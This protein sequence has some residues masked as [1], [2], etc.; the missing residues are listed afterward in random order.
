MANAASVLQF[1]GDWGF[2]V[3]FG[4]PTDR[5]KYL[6]YPDFPS[7]MTFAEKAKIAQIC[8]T[9]PSMRTESTHWLPGSSPPSSAYCPSPPM[10]TTPGRQH[11]WNTNSPP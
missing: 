9:P 7:V 8:R 1:N 10:A 6:V 2:V 4:G 3:L 5:P 11:N